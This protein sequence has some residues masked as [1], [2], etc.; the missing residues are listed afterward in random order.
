MIIR[1][2]SLLSTLLLLELEWTDSK[3]SIRLLVLNSLLITLSPL[4]L[5]NKLH[6]ALCVFDHR[7]LYLKCGWR[8]V[9]CTAEGIF[10]G[11]NFMDVREGEHVSDGNIFQ[12]GY[13]DQVPWSYEIF[14]A[15]YCCDCVLRRLRAY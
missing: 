9:R 15:C 8:D 13:C 2:V 11:T 6:L 1:P 14:S 4:L 7:G 5:H 10:A 3:T 12:S